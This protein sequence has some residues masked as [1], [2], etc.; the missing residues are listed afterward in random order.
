MSKRLARVSETLQHEISS[1]VK[2][3]L[4]DPR[5]EGITITEVDVSP[6]LKYATV[7]ITSLTISAEEALKALKKAKGKIKSYIGKELSLRYLPELDFKEDKSLEQAEKIEKIIKN[8][9]KENE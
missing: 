6:D 3:E 2:K 4:A 1:I 5:L 7:Y 9:H 8:I